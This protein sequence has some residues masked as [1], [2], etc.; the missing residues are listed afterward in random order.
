MLTFD[1]EGGRATALAGRLHG[2]LEELGLYRR[3]DRPWLP[4]LTVLRFRE[5]PRL[6]AA[7]ARARRRSFRPTPLFSFP[8]CARRAQLRGSR[9]RA[10]RA[11]TRRWMRLDREQALET[12]LGQIER[13][14]GK[15]AVMKMSDQAQVSVGAISTGSLAARPRARHRRAAARPRRRDLRPRVLGQDDARLPR[16]RRG[17]A[18]RRHLRLHRRRA[19]DGP[20]LRQADRRQHRRAAR[21]AARHRRA[22]ARDHRAPRALGRARRWSRSTPSRR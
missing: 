18:A 17:A 19:R 9:S 13:N 15:G 11:L 2:A 20:D 12:A 4:H 7:A 21:L 14:F 16:D 22:G 3:E 8:G 5:R 10:A 1:D 6:A